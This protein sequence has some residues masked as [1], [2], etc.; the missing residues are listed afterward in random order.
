MY[1]EKNNKENKR[2][3]TESKLLEVLDDRELYGEEY[4]KSTPIVSNYYYK[5]NR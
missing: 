1:K 4:Y 5:S 3:K 2:E